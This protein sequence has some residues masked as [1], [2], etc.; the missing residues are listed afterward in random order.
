MD[1]A[2]IKECADPALKIEIVERFVAAVGTSDYLKITVRAGERITLVP[3]PDNPDAAMSLIQQ[4]VGKA[5]V[6]VGITQYPA[7]AWHQ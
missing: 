7:G 6:R 5:D 4:Y 1:A 3:K 2:L